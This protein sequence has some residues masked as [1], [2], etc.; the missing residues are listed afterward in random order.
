MASAN[1]GPWKCSAGSWHYRRF[2]MTHSCILEIRCCGCVFYLACGLFLGGEGHGERKGR[3]G[4]GMGTHI[5]AMPLS[6]IRRAMWRT[7]WDRVLQHVMISTELK[8]ISAGELSSA[9]PVN[10]EIWMQSTSEV[11]GSSRMQ[12]NSKFHSFCNFCNWIFL[13]YSTYIIVWFF[14]LSLSSKKFCGN[15]WL[16]LALNWRWSVQKEKAKKYTQFQ[17]LVNILLKDLLRQNEHFSHETHN[18]LNSQLFS[19]EYGNSMRLS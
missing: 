7:F 17:N 6:H 10:T 18:R 12:Q 8:S 4:S 2:S 5:N 14:L 3:S 11:V 19:T 13:Q 15:W 1:F 9:A 16:P